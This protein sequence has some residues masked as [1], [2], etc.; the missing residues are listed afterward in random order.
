MRSGTKP[1]RLIALAVVTKG[2]GV[3]G[4]AGCGGTI[5]LPSILHCFP[6]A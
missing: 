5:A 1:R 6:F 2:I 4:D 3:K